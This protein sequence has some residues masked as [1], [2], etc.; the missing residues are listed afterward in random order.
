M[1][2]NV[3]FN[4]LYQSNL[5]F[6]RFIFK[7]YYWRDVCF[8]TVGVSCFVS[9]LYHCKSTNH[10]RAHSICTFLLISSQ[11]LENLGTWNINIWPIFVAIISD[12][13]I[14]CFIRNDWVTN[15]KSFKWFN[16]DHT[17]HENSMIIGL[18]CS[19]M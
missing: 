14:I 17:E 10:H 19:W 3:I 6:F 16:F 11:Y 2:K 12:G 4:I 18:W 9:C 13:N 1:L 7:Y 15:N 5:T 8:S